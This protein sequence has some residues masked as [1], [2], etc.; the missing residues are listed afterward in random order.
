MTD[1][2]TGVKL[3]VFGS[4]QQS[5]DKEV[6]TNLKVRI[7]EQ[8]VNLVQAGQVGLDSGRLKVF[9]CMGPNREL[10]EE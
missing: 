8:L 7:T 6:R 10:A 1:W 3:T 4:F 2:I 9:F 5:L